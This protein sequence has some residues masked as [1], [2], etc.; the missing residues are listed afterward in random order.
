MNPNIYWIHFYFF[1][2]K[3][4]DENFDCNKN[5]RFVFENIKYPNR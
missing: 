5:V 3:P 4:K 2:G 1:W